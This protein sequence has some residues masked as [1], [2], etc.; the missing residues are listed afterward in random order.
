MT[1]F[2]TLLALWSVA[3]VGTATLPGGYGTTPIDGSIIRHEGEP[4]GKEETYNNR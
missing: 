4:V 1:K 2:T 3:S